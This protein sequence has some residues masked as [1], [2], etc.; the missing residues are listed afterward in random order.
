MVFAKLP[1]VDGSVSC[2]S[3][4][5]GAR[6]DLEPER[7]IAVGLGSAGYSKNGET[8]WEDDPHSEEDPRTVATVEALAAADPDADWRIFF[9]APLY[10]AEYQRQGN[11]EWVLVRKGQGFA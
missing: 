2:L 4:G 5:A 9:V 3:C 6:T 8:L 7:E 1:P 11:N 10:E